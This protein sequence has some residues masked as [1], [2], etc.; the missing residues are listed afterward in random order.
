MRVRNPR[1]QMPIEI[2]LAEIL[3]LPTTGL[4]NSN[5]VSSK[6]FA[7]ESTISKKTTA[8]KFIV[9]DVRDDDNS[10]APKTT[11]ASKI[12]MTGVRGNDDPE[13]FQAYRESLQNVDDFVYDKI[14]ET[15]RLSLES[16]SN[17]SSG[18]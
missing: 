1:P 11:T 3:K 13:K 10:T 7:D 2:G 14:G 16:F 12:T 18:P 6:K 17:I 4:F 9:T 8:S 15:S 5:F